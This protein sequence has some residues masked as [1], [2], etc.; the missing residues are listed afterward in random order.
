MDVFL[1]EEESHPGRAI[2]AGFPEEG[3]SGGTEEELE[4]VGIGCGLRE[5]RGFFTSAAPAPYKRP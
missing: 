2:K 3:A 5:S 4:Y 1:R